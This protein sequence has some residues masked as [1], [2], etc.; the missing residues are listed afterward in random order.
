MLEKSL[1]NYQTILL[2][3]I[4]RLDDQSMRF[5]NSKNRYFELRLNRVNT[6]RLRLKHPND[7]IKM[8]EQRFLQSSNRLHRSAEN[9]Y[10][11]QEQ[12]FKLASSLLNSYSYKK[13]L[14]RGFAILTDSKSNALTSASQAKTGEKLTAELNDGKINLTIN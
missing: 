9:Y 12:R 11:A 7:I 14:S 2:N 6:L 13:T 1:P 10:N 4:Q 5:V 8:A 3:F